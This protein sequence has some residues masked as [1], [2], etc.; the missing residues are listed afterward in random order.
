MISAHNIIYNVFGY[1]IYHKPRSILKSIYQDIQNKNI[2]IFIVNDTRM[3]RYF[4]GTHRAFRLRKV[5]QAT[6]L[7]VEFISIP[8]NKKFEKLVG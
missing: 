7:S 4:M 3:A 6:I 8:N 2:G 5:L 1:G